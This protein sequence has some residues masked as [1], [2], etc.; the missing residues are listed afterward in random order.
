MYQLDSSDSKFGRCCIE[1]YYFSGQTGRP[2]RFPSNSIFRLLSRAPWTRRDGN[3]PLVPERWLGVGVLGPHTLPGSQGAPL[4][5]GSPYTKDARF[6]GRPEIADFWG[7]D[8]PGGRD[9]PFGRV[10]RAAGAAQT[11]KIINFRSVKNHALKTQIP[12]DTPPRMMRGPQKGRPGPLI[13]EVGCL[14]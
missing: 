12:P 5:G 10:F 8:G 3:E 7:L 14:N 9:N 1:L 11:T 4:G 6:S 13:M 2:V